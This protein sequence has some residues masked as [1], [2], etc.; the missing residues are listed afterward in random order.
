M[1]ITAR[2]ALRFILSVETATETTKQSLIDV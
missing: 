1:E 2:T